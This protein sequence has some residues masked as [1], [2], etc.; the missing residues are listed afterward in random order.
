MVARIYRKAASWPDRSGGNGYMGISMGSHRHTGKSL[1]DII[2][3]INEDSRFSFLRIGVSDTLNR[4]NV[5]RQEALNQGD[6]W[7]NEQ[8]SSLKRLE[9]PHEIYRWDHWEAQNPQ[10]VEE[11]RAMYR[12]ALNTDP[13]FCRAIMGDVSGFKQRRGDTGP[14]VSPY[15]DYLIEELAVY[16]EIYRDFPNT[17]IYPGN[18]LKVAEYLREGNVSQTFK[19]SSFERLYVTVENKADLRLRA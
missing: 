12:H 10:R 7:L 8:A 15:I 6:Q 2:D 16:E 3:W 1:D 13:A 17:T 5:G 19:N 11:N 4:F 14:D 9:I 18:Q